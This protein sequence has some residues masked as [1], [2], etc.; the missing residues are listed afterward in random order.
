M[1]DAG[2]AGGGLGG[3]VIRIRGWGRGCCCG[4]GWGFCWFRGVRGSRDGGILD[5]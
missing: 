2:G 3:R 1:G 5:E 4:V